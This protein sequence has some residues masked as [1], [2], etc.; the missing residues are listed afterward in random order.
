MLGIV[1]QAAVSVAV[2][3]AARHIRIAAAEGTHKRR[4]VRV[5]LD[6]GHRHPTVGRSLH[7]V[8]VAAFDGG[9]GATT[10]S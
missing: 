8:A 6:V 5:V 2:V 3:V 9:G 1:A 7:T 10:V 4:S